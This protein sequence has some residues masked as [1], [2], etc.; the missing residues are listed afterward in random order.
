MYEQ[1]DKMKFLRG[2]Q[3]YT[4]VIAD[5]EDQIDIAR[6]KKEAAVALERKW[7]EDMMARLAESE[8]RESEEAARRK[9]KHKDISEIQQKQLEDTKNKLVHQLTTAFV[10]GQLIKQ[11]AID[12]LVEEQRIAAEKQAEAKKQNAEMLKANTNLKDL[13]KELL[14]VEQIEA[15]KR[16][17]EVEHMEARVK[18]RHDLEK[19]HFEERQKIRMQLIEVATRDLE[20][21]KHKEDT[22]LDKHKAES[23]Q[24]HLEE[25]ERRRLRKEK[26]DEAIELSR[27]MQ[28]R[29]KEERKVADKQGAQILAE[30]WKKRNAEL[31]EEQSREAEDRFNKNLEIR[32]SQ[33]AQVLENRR[34]A[35]ELK[36]NE[37]LRDE[38]TKA[39]MLEDDDRFRDFAQIEIERF[40]A[41]GKKTFLLERARDA[42]DIQLLAG[43]HK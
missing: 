5:R 13:R 36:A 9:A 31:E 4:D 30:C 12:D 11:M 19:K 28:I 14:K 35:A 25:M 6:K 42:K 23:E 27:R 7:H 34:I 8:R 20:S 17:K 3:L 1:T 15:D 10:E 22:I 18:G 39:V 37:I 16:K 24:K 38:Q 41:K 26:A 2:Q 29:L 21:R 33:E 43:K 32:R 40:R